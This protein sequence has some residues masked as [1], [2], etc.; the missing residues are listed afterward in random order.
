M[1]DDQRRRRSESSCGEYTVATLG[2]EVVDILHHRSKRR[3]LTV[4]LLASFLVSIRLT[5]SLIAP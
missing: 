5:L 4:L 2:I 3:E 1:M